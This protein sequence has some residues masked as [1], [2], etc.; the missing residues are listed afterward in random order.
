MATGEKR[1]EKEG[2]NEVP[3]L[4]FLRHAALAGSESAK[5]GQDFLKVRTDLLAQGRDFS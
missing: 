4:L 3:S 5:Q 1:N 2:A